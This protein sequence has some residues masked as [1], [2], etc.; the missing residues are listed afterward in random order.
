VASPAVYR[1][2]VIEPAAVHVV[3]PAE[4]EPWTRTGLRVRRGDRVTLLGSGTVRWSGG[5]GAGAKHHLRG[6]IRGGAVFGCTRDTT[7]VVVDRTGELELRV[8]LGNRAGR[9]GG[10]EVTVLHWPAGTDPVAGLAAVPAT[11]ADPALAAAERARLLDPVV[12]PPGWVYDPALGPGEIFRHAVV[13]GRPAAS[14]HSTRTAGIL[15]REVDAPLGPGT[16]LEWSWRV[17]A[18]PADGPEDRCAHHDHLGIGVGFGGGPALSWFW[19][20][21]HAPVDRAFA[22]PAPGWGERE[23]HVAVRGGPLGLGRWRREGRD[24]FADHTRF[25]GAPPPRIDAIRLLAVSHVGGG[26]GRA[27]FADVAVVAGGRRIRVL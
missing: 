17:E 1:G 19:S 18:L 12:P 6:R 22:C 8:H 20:S 26:T 14:T 3:L 23:T 2:P 13:D 5:G 7:T 15:T 4:R 11:V 24:L 27:T 10:L 25:L 16:R 21:G 9:R